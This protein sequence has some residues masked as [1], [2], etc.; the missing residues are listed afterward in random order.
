MTSTPRLPRG[1]V[2]LA[3]VDLLLVVL[4]AV[5]AVQ[6]LAGPGSAPAARS[7]SSTAATTPAPVDGAS[8][9]A[10]ESVF[11]L[12]SGNIA[13]RMTTDGVTCT[14]RSRTFTPPPVPGCTQGNG[15]VVVLDAHGLAVPCEKD[16]VPN[17]QGPGTPVL[18]YGRRQ[19]VG[20]YT[21]ESAT[22]GVTCTRTD[23]HGFR[24]ARAELVELP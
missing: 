24:L 20:D 12:P 19:A 21:C 3:V 7:T 18:E 6:V 1:L 15:R 10:Q 8:T 13:C 16:A 14:I 11:E 2:I 17:L 9:G 4:L 22:T 23:G 5:V